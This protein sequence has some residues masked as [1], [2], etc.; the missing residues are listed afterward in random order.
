MQPSSVSPGARA[1]E[2]EIDSTYLSNPLVGYS[3]G[4]AAWYFLAHCEER[5]VIPVLK[6][7][8]AVPQICAA[9]PISFV[10]A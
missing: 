1:A 3:F 8:L 10:R 2:K 7:E 4:E 9:S 5:L 6:S